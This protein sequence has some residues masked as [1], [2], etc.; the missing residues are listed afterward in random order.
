M[1]AVFHWVESAAPLHTNPSGEPQF[2]IRLIII[3][4]SIEATPD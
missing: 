1:Q 4:F 2:D 3:E